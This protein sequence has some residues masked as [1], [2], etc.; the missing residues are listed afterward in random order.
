M[1]VT[2]LFIIAGVSSDQPCGVSAAPDAPLVTPPA[3]ICA[4][5][6]GV[7]STLPVSLSMLSQ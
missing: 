6:S 7:L 1:M 4:Q 2:A 3:P 5:L